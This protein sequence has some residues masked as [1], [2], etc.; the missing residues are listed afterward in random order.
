MGLLKELSETASRINPAL[1][2]T[3]NKDSSAVLFR[4]NT[5]KRGARL[6]DE[7]DFYD[8]REKR[9]RKYSEW[10]GI[11]DLFESNNPKDNWR[12]AMTMDAV[13]K[14]QAFLENARNVYG[15]A[16]VQTSLGALNPRVLDVVRIFYPQP[17]VA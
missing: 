1:L 17:E 8:V 13:A 4:E 10:H 12:A 6:F 14:T 9:N 16:T 5:I 3:E 15:E 11:G 2:M 7:A